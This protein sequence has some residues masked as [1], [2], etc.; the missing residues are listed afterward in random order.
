MK[1]PTPDAQQPLKAVTAK[2]IDVSQI[3]GR[4]AEA[5]WF[6]SLAALTIV[7][8]CPICVFLNCISVTHFSGA[9]DTTFSTLSDL[10]LSDFLRQY[11][12][13]PSSSAAL[14]YA[15]WLLFQALLFTILPGPL[16]TGQRTPAGYLLKYRTNGLFAWI[17][18]HILFFGL[19]AL[20]WLDLA[21]I[22][23]NFEGLTVAAIIYG[24]LLPIPCVLKAHIAPSHP[25]DRKFSGS[26]IF[27]YFVGIELNPR[28]GELW[29]FKLFH[30]G[31]PG[32]TA[33]TLV[34]FSF[35]AKQYQR[36]GKVSGSMWVV[37]ALHVLYVVDFFWNEDWYLR[38]IDITH[39]HFGYYLGTSLV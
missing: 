19:G 23:N 31:R 12:P 13:R 25:D 1:A 10:G 39:D 24:L 15:A 36:F 27:D 6:A 4:Q 38:T 7:L 28:F 2:I 30:N 9:Y 18:T 14:G 8:I 32:I 35:T 37:D 22:A 5:D 17:I 33:W 26:L 16:S 29:D 34:S 20:G 21:I 11:L 3:W